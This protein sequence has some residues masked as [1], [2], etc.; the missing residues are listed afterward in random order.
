MKEKQRGEMDR[1]SV[2]PISWNGSG[3]QTLTKVHGT[4]PD[5][6]MALMKTAF[7]C[8]LPWGMRIVVG[9]S[10]RRCPARA[11]DNIGTAYLPSPAYSASGYDVHNHKK[12][13]SKLELKVLLW[14]KKLPVLLK[15]GMMGRA[16]ILSPLEVEAGGF[17][18][19][20]QRRLYSK[21]FVSRKQ[22]KAVCSRDGKGG[23]HNASVVHEAKDAGRQG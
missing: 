6:V 5:P 14:G 23:Q 15:Q 4:A 20:S 22:Q 8:L 11:V 18:V 16:Y 7:L 17:Q 12:I 19:L 10:G 21:T 1:Q 9:W 2:S 3:G 13:G